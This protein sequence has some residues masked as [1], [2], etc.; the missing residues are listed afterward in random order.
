M[1]NSLR[2]LLEGAIDYAGMF[3]PARLSLHEAIAEYRARRTETAAWLLGR[4]VCPVEQLG[5][6]LSAFPESG[7]KASLVV[8]IA[9]SKEVYLRDIVPAVSAARP[10]PTVRDPL[11]PIG[12]VDALEFRWQVNVVRD[13]VMARP[14]NL[15]A[16]A[17]SL[18]TIVNANASM[19]CELPRIDSPARSAAWRRLLKQTLRAIS[20][21][22]ARNTRSKFLHGIAGF[23]F[24]CGGPTA[25][26]VPPSAELAEVIR[27][28]RDAR[29]PWKAT[30]GLHH[31]LPHLDSALGV[32]MHGF[33]NLFSAAVLADVHRLGAREIQAILGDENAASFQFGNEELKW[34]DLS[35]TCPQVSQ[36]RQRGLQSFGSCSIDEPVQDLTALGWL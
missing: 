2:A 33:I 8:P 34:R 30:A 20:E 14:D 32:T 15:L 3:P 16:M 29:V 6:L 25:A 5:A 1:T 18:T 10:L 19:Y 28:C 13:D 9:Y 35:A 11:P 17:S 36:A 24:R 23:K 4:F 12:A 22:R 26:D 27:A 21:Q 7:L 31:P